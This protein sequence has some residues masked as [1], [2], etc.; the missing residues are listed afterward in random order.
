MTRGSC[1]R[2]VFA[3]AL[4]ATVGALHHHVDDD[5]SV[6]FQRL[7]KWAI[8]RIT[9]AQITAM[10]SMPAGVR[11][12]L[13]TDAPSIDID[14]QLT[15][16]QIDDAPLMPAVFDVV[17]DG[18][19]AV[20]SVATTAG[21]QVRVD[22]R[23][24][25]TDVVPAGPTTISVSGLPGRPDSQ[26]E[27]WL[28]RNAVVRLRDV[29]IPSDCDASPAPRRSPVWVHHG[30]S[31]SHCLDAARPTDAWP[32]LVARR[33]GVSLLDL[34]F[35]GEC[36]LDQF[37]ARAIRDA[38]VDAISLKLGANVVG[39]DIMRE[40]AFVPALHGFLDTI[41]DGHPT[42]PLVVA[43][44]IHCPPAESAP[45][46]TVV[47][48]DGRAACVPRP[49]EL[50][51]GALTIEHVH[52]LIADVVNTRRAAGDP[53]CTSSTGCRCSAGTTPRGSPTGSIR[54]APGTGWWPIASAASPSVRVGPSPISVRAQ[55]PRSWAARC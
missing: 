32:V 3:R 24:G 41:R 44:P 5:G 25:A 34:G 29:R 4:E 23:T 36:Q 19:D 40:R 37:T 14:V 35:A 10:V 1:Q 30:S 16:L 52:A 26:V 38:A 28:P 50:S 47:G 22:Q 12:E 17:I 8:D 46:P 53:R 15:L 21:T 13:L 54:T 11:I 43:S 27:I 33:A 39:H 42:T 31:I 51:A 48:P 6:M 9:D 45:G 55:P 7:P 18:A 2:S 49:P 20:R